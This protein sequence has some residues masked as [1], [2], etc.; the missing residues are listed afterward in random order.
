MQRTNRPSGHKVRPRGLHVKAPGNQVITKR[1]LDEKQG[2]ATGQP[3]IEVAV[4]LRFSANPSLD[5][6]QT[7]AQPGAV[8]E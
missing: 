2:L 7:R 6:A 1:I 3:E 4:S 8:P 5:E